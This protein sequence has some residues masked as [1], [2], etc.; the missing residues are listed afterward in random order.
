MAGN[1]DDGGSRG[2]VGQGDYVVS[3]GDCMS[4]IAKAHGHF[5]ETL[6]NHPDNADLKAARRDPNILLPGDRVS[7]PPIRQRDEGRPT[8]QRHTFCRRGEPSKFRLRLIEPKKDERTITDAP[9]PRY[10]GKDVVTEDPEPPSGA[11]E[12]EPRASVPYVLEID[13]TTTNGTTDGDGYVEAVIPGSARAG[14]LVLNPGTAHEEEFR[15]MLGHLDPIS[16]FVGVKQRLAN[17]TFDCGDQSNEMTP[18]LRTAIEAFQ[19]KL[20]L[21]PTG[22]LTDELRQKIRELHGS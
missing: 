1:E 13:G 2:P 6:W 17:L 22:E 3:S 11:V 7:V 5:W 18:G 15:L 20:G 10:E 19:Q 4:S 16:E 14:R 21:E 9:Q 8:D 12:D